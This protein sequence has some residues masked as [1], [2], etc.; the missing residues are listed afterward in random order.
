MPVGSVI[1]VSYNSEAYIEACLLALQRVENWKVI[2]VDNC[3]T[4]KTVER[5]QQ[6]GSKTCMLLNPRNLGFAAAVN[7]GAQVAEG[8]IFV[9]LNPDTISNSYALEKLVQPLVAYDV[10]AAGGLLV[11]SGEPAEN[12][13]TVRR[14]PTLASM[15]VQ[16]F[17]LNHIWPKNPWNRHYRC[18]DLNYRLAQEVDQPAGA[19]LAVKRKAWED[20]GGFDEG[21][22]PVW[23]EDVDF[24]RRL[25]SSGWKIVYCP[26]A[27]FTHAGGHSVNS[28]RFEEKQAFWYRNLL[29]YFA[30]HHTRVEVSLLQASVVLGLLFRVLLS[31]CGFQPA[32]VSAREALTAYWHVAYRCASGRENL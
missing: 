26:D 16:V 18:L 2:L 17:L 11:P 31:L 21:F 20:V 32:G 9:I 29:R 5:A 10:G 7:Q 22:F 27:V 12:G 13:F 6:V 19:C 24:C 14:F 23:F 15:L 28:L 1:V 8:D 25:R 3:S 30:K 4:D